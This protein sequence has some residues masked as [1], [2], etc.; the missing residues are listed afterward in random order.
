MTLS[1]RRAEVD[2]A[3]AAELPVRLA[4]QRRHQATATRAYA[5]EL[6]AGLP[7]EIAEKY[8]ARLGTARLTEP[9][10]RDGEGVSG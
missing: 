4:R 2:E 7:P 5:R 6:A 3:L 10:P 9:R 1:I 8:R